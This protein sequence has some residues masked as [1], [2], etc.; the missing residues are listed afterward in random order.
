MTFGLLQPH[1]PSSK[2]KSSTTIPSTDP[3]QLILNRL[4]LMQGCITALKA[5]N[6][7]ASS[8]EITTAEA[9]LARGEP[10]KDKPSSH[11]TP[12]ATKVEDDLLQKK[13]RFLRPEHPINDCVLCLLTLLINILQ[14]G[15]KRQVST[16]LI[17]SV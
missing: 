8:C 1:L 3:L 15:W 4:D 14:L 2:D 12:F 10:P 6:S 9:A 13:K 7:S 5:S 16:P 11:H 17:G